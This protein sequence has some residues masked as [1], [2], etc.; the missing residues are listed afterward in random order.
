MQILKTAFI[1]ALV[2]A[3][4]LLIGC[5]R[6]GENNTT[7][8]VNSSASNSQGDQTVSA[9]D[10]IEEFGTVVNIPFEPEEVVWKEEAL[11]K[12]NG[13][14][15]STKKLIAVMKFSREDAKKIVG[16]SEKI[17]PGEAAA[18]GTERWFPA[19]LI[20]KS[21]M[22]GTDSLRGVSYSA[23]DFYLPPYTS[24]TITRVEN[25]DF[26]ILELLAKQL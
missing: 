7:S 2:F 22:E 20:A 18:V 26:F 17:K 21:E 8:G 15:A 10:N 12:Q 14:Q 1:L 4:Q 13:E 25:T 11:P 19:E 23:A 16:Q 9:N 6:S 24:G 5:G 3:V